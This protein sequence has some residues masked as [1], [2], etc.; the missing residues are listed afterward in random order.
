MLLAILANDRDVRN[1]DGRFLLD[2]TAFDIALRVRSSMTLDHLDA[3][4]DDLLI[5]W[6]DDQYATGFAPVFSTQD[7]YFI[8]FLDWR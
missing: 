7:E 3:F 5:F 2:D 1:V 6:H 4:D 8:V